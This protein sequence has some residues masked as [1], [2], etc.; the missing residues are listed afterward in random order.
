V[1][2][3][4]LPLSSFLPPS[5]NPTLKYYLVLPYMTDIA[6][7]L[8]KRAVVALWWK[9]SSLQMPHKAFSLSFLSLSLSG[10]G[11]WEHTDKRQVAIKPSLTN[12]CDL[13][14]LALE[15]GHKYDLTNCH[16][17]THLALEGGEALS[18]QTD[19]V[20][21]WHSL[22]LGKD[23]AKSVGTLSVCGRP[24]KKYWIR[25]LDVANS[26]F[27]SKSLASRIGNTQPNT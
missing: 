9:D 20:I 8:D 6:P 3:K 13:T 12:C 4:T 19:Q 18:D 17:L 21:I 24:Q 11:H 27:P 16:Y 5:P 7:T 15:G 2:V 23:S 1:L 10:N 14:Y 26:G 22:A 25:G